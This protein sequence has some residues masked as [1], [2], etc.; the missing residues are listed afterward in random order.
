MRGGGTLMLRPSKHGARDFS[1]DDLALTPPAPPNPRQRGHD[2][3]RPL[4]GIGHA[5]G[6]G[7]DAT[8]AAPTSTAPTSAAAG[9]RRRRDRPRRRRGWPRRLRRRRW[10]CR[11]RCPA[12]DAQAILVGHAYTGKN[13]PAHL[14]AAPLPDTA[15]CS[16]GVTG[17]RRRRRRATDDAQAILVRHAHTGKDLPT[18]LAPAPLSGGAHRPTGVAGGRCRTGLGWGWGRRKRRREG[19][20]RWRTMRWRDR[21]AGRWGFRATDDAH[22]VAVRDALTWLD[23]AVHL[24]PA[25]F[26]CFTYC[27]AGVAHRRCRRR[28]TAAQRVG[29][30]EDVADT[31]G[32]AVHQVRGVR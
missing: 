2:D 8:A 15:Y 12:N 7:I 18:H 6:D 14:P 24:A 21:R 29:H 5:P 22:T 10:R 17:G 28:S 25:A 20:R 32:V 1:T 30:D 19:S 3:R 31:V 13:L 27:P 11:C 9:C 26:T 16:A 4:H 23:P